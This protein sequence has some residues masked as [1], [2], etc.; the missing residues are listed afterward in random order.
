LIERR[1]S[2]IGID[3]PAAL[4]ALSNARLIVLAVAAS[5]SPMGVVV[6]AGT[7]TRLPELL[8]FESLVI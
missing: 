1:I 3:P 5:C 4:S 6:G 2:Q 7:D 8:D